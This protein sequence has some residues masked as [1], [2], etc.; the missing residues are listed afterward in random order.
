LLIKLHLTAP[1]FT[2]LWPHMPNT[3]YLQTILAITT[4]IANPL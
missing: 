3:D 4:F 2:F 1:Y